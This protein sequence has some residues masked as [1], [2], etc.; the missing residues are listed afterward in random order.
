M[1]PATADYVVV[2]GGLTG[3]VIASSLARSASSPSVILLEAGPDPSGE[4]GT[5]TILAGLGLLGGKLDYAYRS[6]P[7]T[8]TAGRVHTLPAGRALGGGSILNFGGWLQ[9]DAHDYDHWGEAVGDERWSYRGMKPWLDKVEQRFGAASISSDPRRKYPL[10]N[11]V[12]NAWKELG[13]QRTDGEIGSMTGLAELKENSRDGLRQPSYAAYPLKSVTVFT[14]V[15]VR[16]VTFIGKKATGVEL[17][18]SRI[19]KASKEVIICA[20]AYRTPQILMLSGIGAPEII[21]THSIPLVH[22]APGVGNNLFD[23]FAIYMAFRLSDPSQSLAL[24]SPGWTHPSLFKGLPY[25]WVASERVPE[26][27]LEKHTEHSELR[28]R[29]L[30]EV[31]VVYVTPGIPGIPVDGTHIAT[32]TMLLLP[33]SRGTVSLS[34]SSPNDPPKIQPNYLST[35]L[36]REV[37]MYA[38]R[39]TLTVMLGTESMKQCIESETPPV[40]PELEGLTPLTTYVADEVLW[41]R[42]ERS[43]MQHH[44]SGGTAAMGTV[45]DAEGRVVGVEGLRIADASVLPVP[46]GGHPQVTLY[47]MA[48]QIASCIIG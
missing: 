6:E 19:V 37:L 34:S 30:F 45:V 18:D 25:D 33:T 48:E 5:D 39:R 40:G 20:G 41:E 29:N 8:Q 7:V 2:G 22:A 24:G 1:E 15:T 26:E 11:T 14:D 16:R 17:G 43:G 13:V 12:E 27:W 35:E 28:T 31:L 38:A 42:I 3:C 46:L 21:S 32:S 10:R 36:D 4:P 47:A 44:H 9:G 23:H